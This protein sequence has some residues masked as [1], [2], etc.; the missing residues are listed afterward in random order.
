MT[1]PTLSPVLAAALR[2]RLVAE[3]GARRRRR[4]RAVWTAGA[5]VALIVGGTSAAVASGVLPL[6]GAPHDTALG[7]ARS[8]EGQGPGALDLG[9]V[10]AG[11][12]DIA[13]TLRCLDAGTFGLP[14]SGS[15]V[16]DG[17]TDSAA[18]WT[19]AV[20]AVDPSRLAV[21]ADPGARWRLT[22]G[23]ASREIAPLATNADGETY[24]S[25]AGGET[26]DLIAVLATNGQDGYVRR[27]DLEEADGTAAA[28][29]FRS[30]ADALAWQEQHAGRVSAIPVYEADG[31]TVVGT[32]VVGS[33]PGP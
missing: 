12:T 24:G 17:P 19:V 27:T 4:R 2:V 9:P 33:A 10:P 8:V 32:F 20:N 31:R 28:E 6:P 14:G 11:A 5:V 18:S 30:P 29:S 1:T 22:A 26:P 16:C 21:V 3:V 23:Y 13:L 15:L 7:A 25:V